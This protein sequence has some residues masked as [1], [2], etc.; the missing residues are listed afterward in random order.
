MQ[1]RSSYSERP[2]GHIR[3]PGFHKRSW[4]PFGRASVRTWGVE[5][6]HRSG[7]EVK[8]HL[9]RAGARKEPA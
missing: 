9:R 7:M 3:E 6:E 4:E 1:A 2:A 5:A 8:T